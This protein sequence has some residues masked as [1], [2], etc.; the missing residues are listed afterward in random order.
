MKKLSLEMA[1]GCTK[2]VS[3]QLEINAAD[4][5]SITE[6]EWE[7]IKSGEP[8]AVRDRNSVRQVLQTI[9]YG[10][11][12]YQ[13]LPQI[14]IPAEYA[15][16]LIATVVHP[17][18]FFAASTWLGTFS[19]GSDLGHKDQ[20]LP[21]EVTGLEK[22]TPRQI[23]SLTMELYSDTRFDRLKRHFD[24]FT[25]PQIEILKQE[26]LNEGKNSRQTQDSRTK[27]VT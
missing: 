12:E 21:G 5:L 11:T 2:I 25:E 19:A 27:K 18:N 7:K 20:N 14:E 10:I 6:D 23:L 15:A 8:W 13:G 1:I 24:A 4:T 9:L 26:V 16:A 22:C 3:K 17:V